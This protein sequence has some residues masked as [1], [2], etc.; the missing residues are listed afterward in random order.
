MAACPWCGQPVK[1]ARRRGWAAKRFCSDT[2]RNS[3]H[4]AARRWVHQ[5]IAAGLLTVDIIRNASRRPCTPSGL[6]DVAVGI[7]DAQSS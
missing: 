3:F 5:A 6:P 4:S 7:A 1:P 2:C